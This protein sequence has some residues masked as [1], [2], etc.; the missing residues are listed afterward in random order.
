[1]VGS[2]L[3]DLFKY[4]DLAGKNHLQ[5]ATMLIFYFANISES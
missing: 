4:M 1:M 5:M 3:T 2:F